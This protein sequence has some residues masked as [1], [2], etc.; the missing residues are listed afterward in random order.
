MKVF[1][2]AAFKFYFEKLVVASS[3]ALIFFKFIFHILCCVLRQLNFM[4][5]PW[6]SSQ[7]SQHKNTHISEDT[8][9]CFT[10]HTSLP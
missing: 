8:V 2:S 3:F 5:D 10:I 4:V 1:P 6:H 7:S 9:A